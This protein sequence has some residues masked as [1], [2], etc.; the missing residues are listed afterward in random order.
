MCVRSHT[1]NS[2]AIQT[3]PPFTKQA[4]DLEVHTGHAPCYRSSLTTPRPS[5][6]AEEL[7][8][9][10]SSVVVVSPQDRVCR[11]P[12]EMTLILLRLLAIVPQSVRAG[13]CDLY[14]SG[15]TPCV[16]AHSTVR[17]LLD[18][19]TGPL[20]E[21]LRGSDGTTI[22]IMPVTAGG[23]ASSAPQDSF[24]QMT[25]CL[26]ST[27]YDQ[28]GHSNHLTAAPPGGAA[29]GPEPGGYD[30]LASAVGAPITIGGKKA[31][32]V[33]TT[34]A[35]GYRIDNTNDIAT[36]NQAEGIYAV[37]DGTHY[38]GNC[39]W[40][41]GNAEV[42]NR[43]NN[44]THMEALYFGSAK[45]T[46]Y[47]T[48]NGPWI[49]ADLE[50]G[51]FAGNQSGSVNPNNPS[52][53]YRFTTGIVKGASTNL[54]SIRG[55]NAQSGGLSTFYSGP[56]PPGYYPMNKEGA[57]ILGIG[58]DNSDGAQGTFYEGA[59]TKG[60]PHDA[61]ESQVQANIV[62][63]GY[64][65]TSEISGPALTVG[66][67]VS[68]KA[69]T[70]QAEY[71]GHNGSNVEIMP[72]SLASGNARKQDTS[73]T[74]T[75]GNGNSGCY[76]FEAVN[77]PGSFLRHYA[78]QLYCD[79]SDS[80]RSPSTFADD[81]TFCPESGLIGSG[82]SFRSW[83][84]PTRYWRRI[85]GGDIYIGMNGGPFAWDSASQYNEQASWTVEAGFA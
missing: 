50:N 26:I 85:N 55:G 44:A 82:T 24:C 18:A 5:F 74:V 69:T 3:V 25:T 59:M 37:V 32:G 80:S 15:G 10:Y 79:P 67:S 4:Q 19:Y 34:S 83:S 56:R 54:W 21:V 36:G 31:Y 63:A 12:K 42:N 77:A 20:Y 27:I 29:S 30:F 41:Y 33:F 23:V 13:P 45:G 22:D 11:H 52:I 78:Y 14:A 1:A 71:I 58:G 57:I 7:H 60:Y 84:Y 38:N 35:T 53:D 16:A 64:A 76:S 46:A 2:A 72:A 66:S 39:C 65:T 28:S 43:D 40:D 17:A 81:S 48:G 61:I 6:R 75:V 51:L 68:I 49:Q 9:V 47:G 73:F 8:I 70:N 62:A